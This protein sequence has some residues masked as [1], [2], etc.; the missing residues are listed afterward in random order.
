VN[1]LFDAAVF[2][3]LVFGGL[4]LAMLLVFWLD[5]ICYRITGHSPIFLI[6]DAIMK[7][8]NRK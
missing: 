4:A 7:F 5:F 1:K 6:D 8:I 2:M 3:F